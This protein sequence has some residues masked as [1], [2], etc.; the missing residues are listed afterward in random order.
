MNYLMLAA[1][2][3]NFSMAKHKNGRYMLIMTLDGIHYTELLKAFI[4]SGMSPCI[5]ELSVVMKETYK[6]M[7][8]ELVKYYSNQVR[9]AKIL[10]MWDMIM[11]PNT[12]LE[13]V[14]MLFGD[15]MHLFSTFVYEIGCDDNHNFIF[16]WAQFIDNLWNLDTELVDLW[17]RRLM[18]RIKCCFS[19]YANAL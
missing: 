5:I 7:L 4:G 17:E 1:F 3:F 6:W 16:T 18:L 11:G 12:P 13:E 9:S 15:N 14:L 19:M 10:S 2:Q 8:K